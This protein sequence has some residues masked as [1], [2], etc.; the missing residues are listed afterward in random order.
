MASYVVV[1]VLFICVYLHEVSAGVFRDED[2]YPGS[3][4]AGYLGKRNKN[5]YQ[6]PPRYQT[7]DAPVLGSWWPNRRSATR[8]LSEIAA[9]ELTKRIAE[10]YPSIGAAYWGK[11]SKEFYPSV[12]QSYWGKRSE[13]I[14]M[15]GSLW[16]GKRSSMPSWQHRWWPGKRSELSPSVGAAYWGKRSEELYPSVAAS[17]WGKRN[18]ELYPGSVAASYWGKR[19]EDMP[20]WQHWPGKRSELKSKND[21]VLKLLYEYVKKELKQ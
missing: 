19:S 5:L 13:E 21:E 7:K 6:G 17:Y 11:R 20:P 3:V 15:L 1:G 14:P 2:T 10:L 8:S 4:A 12:A 16:P 9:D 18:E